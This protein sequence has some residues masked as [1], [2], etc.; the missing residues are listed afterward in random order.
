MKKTNIFTLI[1]LTFI[2]STFISCN[3][4]LTKNIDRE[5]QLVSIQLL[6]EGQKLKQ[7]GERTIGISSVDEV[8]QCFDFTLNLVNTED[9]TKNATVNG[10][11]RTI[12][13]YLSSFRLDRGSWKINISGAQKDVDVAINGSTSFTVGG[14]DSFY[15]LNLVIYKILL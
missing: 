10:D 13:S 3:D 15:V 6:L 9:S 7:A 2:L 8:L 5:K 1:F 12:S 11:I 4:G 14:R